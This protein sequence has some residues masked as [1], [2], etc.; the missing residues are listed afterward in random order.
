MNEVFDDEQLV[1]ATIA[2]LVN[3]HR[4]RLTGTFKNTTLVIV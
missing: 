2:Y 1:V 3:T 4:V